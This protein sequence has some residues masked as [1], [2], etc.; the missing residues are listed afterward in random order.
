MHRWA[1]LVG[2]I[3]TVGISRA[4]PQAIDA[5]CAGERCTIDVLP[6]TGTVRVRIP[7]EATGGKPPTPVSTDGASRPPAASK[8][9]DDPQRWCLDL[10]AGDAVLKAGNRRLELDAPAVVPWSTEGE[11]LSTISRLAKEPLSFEPMAHGE[12]TP[13]PTRS[14]TD[15]VLEGM[16][17][18]SI[19]V[20][21]GA[22][23]PAAYTIAAGEEDETFPDVVAL[24]SGDRYSCSGVVIGPRHVLTARHCLPAQRVA[25]GWRVEALHRVVAIDGAVAHPDPRIDVAL[26]RTKEALPV[27]ARARRLAGDT[28][29][30]Q[31][32][33]R[34]I[35]FG[36][37]DFRTMSGFGTKRHAGVVARGW[38]CDGNRPAR[39]GCDPRAEL[40]LPP[41]THDT[42]SGDSGG[43]LLEQAGGSW[44]LVAITSRAARLGRGACGSGG[45]Y[46]RADVIAPW[47]DSAMEGR[48]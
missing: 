40:V 38:G 46:V 27:R 1:W 25:I 12:K 18:P 19:A 29:P 5:K 45:I 44:R 9:K 39:T 34:F 23:V 16:I 24:G 15:H 10:E 41:S 20:G 8:C 7:I 6:G 31:G 33:V 48:P 2:A 21:N 35:G 30:P 13:P 22:P 11:V 36:V 32:M 28:A 43:P 4:E 3:S 37:N 26:V 47:I 42:C 17:T 14:S